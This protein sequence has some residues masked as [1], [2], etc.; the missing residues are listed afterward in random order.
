MKVGIILEEREGCVGGVEISNSTRG[1]PLRI[2]AGTT[3]WIETN[4]KQSI[5]LKTGLHVMNVHEKVAYC[6]TKKVEIF[7][8]HVMAIKALPKEKGVNL[9]MMNNFAREPSE[10]NV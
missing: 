5:G 4:N 10:S 1:Q 3:S 7:S 6:I 2:R 8:R 9:G